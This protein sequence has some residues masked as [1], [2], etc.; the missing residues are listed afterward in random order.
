[1]EQ[2][3]NRIV[4]HGWIAYRIAAGIRQCCYRR[5]WLACLLE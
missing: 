3:T 4:V 5:V 1:M 2:I